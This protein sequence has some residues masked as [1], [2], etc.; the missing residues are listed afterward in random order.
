MTNS[1]NLNGNEI[2][3]GDTIIIPSANSMLETIKSMAI[4]GKYSRNPI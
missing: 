2:V 4:N 1:I 3:I